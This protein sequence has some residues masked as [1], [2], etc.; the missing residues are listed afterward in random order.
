MA[1]FFALLFNVFINLMNVS[2]AGLVRVCVGAYV[3]SLNLSPAFSML[4]TILIKMNYNTALLH[5]ILK[6]FCLP[7]CIDAIPYQFQRRA[8]GIVLSR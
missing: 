5:S 8:N 4:S 3:P 7:I 6:R 1:I 2:L